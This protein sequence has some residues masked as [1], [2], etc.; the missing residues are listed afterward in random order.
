MNEKRQP[1]QL[2]D[3]NTLES[4]SSLHSKNIHASLFKVI[5]AGNLDNIKNLISLYHNTQGFKINFATQI[6]EVLEPN[7]ANYIVFVPSCWTLKWTFLFVAIF[8]G[9]PDIVAYLLKTFSKDIDINAVCF[10]LLL[11]SNSNFLL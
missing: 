3:I 2:K 8:K 9:F 4:A 6:H 7:D 11:F 10:H 5:A 1:V